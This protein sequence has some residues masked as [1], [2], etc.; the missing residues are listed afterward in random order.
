MEAKEAAAVKKK[1]L[2]FILTTWPK[3]EDSQEIDHIILKQRWGAGN[4]QGFQWLKRHKITLKVLFK[5]LPQLLI[6]L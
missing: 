4:G 5:G 3:N 1:L 2:E 6:I